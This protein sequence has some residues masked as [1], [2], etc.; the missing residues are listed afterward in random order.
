[1]PSP[2]EQL[3]RDYDELKTLKQEFDLAYEQA[4]ETGDLARAKG[5]RVEIERKRDALKEKLCFFEYFP[6]LKQQYEQ[7]KQTLTEV[8][9]LETLSTG[10]MGIKGIDGKE[11]AFPSYQD[12]TERM[13]EKKEI[14]ETKINQGFK[15]LLIV[16]FAMP[17][18]VLIERYK[19]VLFETNK[20]QGG[21]KGTDGKKLDLNEKN[22]I[23]V[24]DDLTQCDNL[25]TPEDKQIEYSVQ[26][27]DG[28]TKE[29]RGGKYK[30]ELLQEDPTNAWQL[31]LLEDMPDLPA[32][33]KGQTINNRKQIEA[34]KSPEE[35]LKLMQTGQY[36]D[37]QGKEQTTEQYENESGLTPEANL[38]LWIAYLRE[39][40][41]AIDDYAGQGKIN[42]LVGNYL[43]G[44]V[45]SFLW[46][47]DYRRPRLDRVYPVFRD[48][49]SAGRPSV[50][51]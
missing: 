4:L 28:K 32:K 29:A 26:N 44:Y 19:Q 24:W 11:Y 40:Q 6:D 3:R 13:K 33:G 51:F 38:I 41:I 35:Y 30:K 9:I 34:G 42:W 17:I 37:E 47:R 16:P 8:S 15:K 46:A 12:I 39:K 36:Q 21:I 49:R 2:C 7:Q 27:Y 48:S 45:P 20:K 14:L 23:D 25:H 43:S 22:P 18:S 31:L 10:E 50:R 1:M 5:L